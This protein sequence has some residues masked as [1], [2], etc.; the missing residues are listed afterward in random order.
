MRKIS[1]FTLILIA[2]KH[3]TVRKAERGQSGRIRNCKQAIK[4]IRQERTVQ[5]LY[6]NNAQKQKLDKHM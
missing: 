2:E 5:A 6:R 1:L 4:Y 3:C